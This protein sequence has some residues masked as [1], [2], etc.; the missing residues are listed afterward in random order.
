MVLKRSSDE[1]GRARGVLIDQHDARHASEGSARSRRHFVDDQASVAR[2]V[3]HAGGKKFVRDVGCLVDETSGVA[4]QIQDD[5]RGLPSRASAK[6]GGRIEELV[7][8]VLLKLLDPHVRHAIRQEP[9][10]HA[11]HMDHLAH[12]IERQDVG[13]ALPFHPHFDVRPWRTAEAFDELVQR[14]GA[15]VL[16]AHAHHDVAAHDPRPFGRRAFDRR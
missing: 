7:V 15:G 3:D 6:L 11:R 12:E 9:G 4:P 5:A 10:R 2:R 13:P 1:L 14:F 8:S 16:T